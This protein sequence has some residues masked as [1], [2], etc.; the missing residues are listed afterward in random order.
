MHQCNS[1]DPTE[2][3]YKFLISGE[4]NTVHFPQLI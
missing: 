1:C 3:M 4:S 2:L